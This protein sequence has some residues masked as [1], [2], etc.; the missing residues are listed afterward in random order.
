[1]K[2]PSIRNRKEYGSVS[3]GR[4]DGGDLRA[5]RFLGDIDP[6]P[7]AFSENIPTEYQTLETEQNRLN[8]DHPLAGLRTPPTH[9]KKDSIMKKGPQRGP[10]SLKSD[11]S[12]KRLVLESPR[13][14]L[15]RVFIGVMTGVKIKRRI[16]ELKLYGTQTV[17]FDIAFK[18]KKAIL[19][20]LF[21]KPAVY[22]LK[23][24]RYLKVPWYIINP[25]S[26]GL[27]VW[28]WILIMIIMYA[29]TVMPYTTAFKIS[30]GVMDSME[31]GMDI[32]FL[33]DVVI[34]FFTAY[35]AADGE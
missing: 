20:A 12:M 14:R 21:P 34:N 9:S 31:V 32:L 24:L 33:I 2:F 16:E 13:R 4:Q 15:K 7:E 5:K 26:T 22:G 30:S 6:M 1:M 29:M 28:N 18:K 23:K 11:L 25:D 3:F 8:P 35:Q 10:Q 19:K 17:L 27:L